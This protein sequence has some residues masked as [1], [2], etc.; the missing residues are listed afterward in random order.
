MKNIL[1]PEIIEYAHG[2]ED[3]PVAWVDLIHPSIIV[4]IKA[5]FFPLTGRQ[6]RVANT[7]DFGMS[8]L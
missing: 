1:G 4:Q 5:S 2:T 6:K 7:D 8:M 3:R